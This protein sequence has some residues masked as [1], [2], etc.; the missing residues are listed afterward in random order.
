VDPISCWVRDHFGQDPISDTECAKIRYVY[1]G[2]LQGSPPG[3]EAKTKISNL[4]FFPAAF[5]VEG[6]IST[7]ND[8]GNKI[9]M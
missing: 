3:S 5:G 4:E 8:R 1:C 6:F 7:S 9:L 2:T